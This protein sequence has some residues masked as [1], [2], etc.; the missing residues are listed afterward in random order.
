MP[1]GI[2]ISSVVTMKGP[3]NVGAQPDVNMWCAQTNADSPHSATMAPT[4]VR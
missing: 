2:E 4:A 3:P 1:V